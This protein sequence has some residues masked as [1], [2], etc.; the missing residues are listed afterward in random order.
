MSKPTPGPWVL[1][2]DTF[3]DGYAYV[4][5]PKRRVALVDEVRKADLDLIAAAPD[6]LEALEQIAWSNDSKW[7]ADC[8]RAAIKKATGEE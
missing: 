1:D 5:A 8:A 2:L 6:L 7:Q 3:E 4:E